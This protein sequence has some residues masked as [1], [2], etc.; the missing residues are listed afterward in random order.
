MEDAFGRPGQRRRNLIVAQPNCIEVPPIWNKMAEAM[1]LKDSSRALGK[2]SEH[3]SFTFGRFKST[4]GVPEISR[5]IV[6]ERGYVIAMQLKAIPF[7][8]QFFR[9]KKVSSGFY[10]V[11]GVSA[12]DLRE[13]PS[14]LLPNPFDV[15]VFY[16]A[17][18]ALDEIAD[19]H[20]TSRVTRLVW[21]HGAYDPVVHGLGRTLL[22]SLALPSRSSKLFVD[23][24][25]Q[26]LNCHFVSIYGGVTLS[27]KRYRGGLSSWQSRRATELLEA[28]LSGNI[29]LGQ[30]AEA[31]GLSVGHFARAFKQTFRRPPYLWLTELRVDRA[32]DLMVNSDL[33]LSEIATQCGFADQSAFN[34]SFKRIHGIP[35]GIWRR[36]YARDN[37]I[38]L[39]MCPSSA[40]RL[41]NQNSRA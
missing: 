27:P 35:P 41:M 34:R 6:G 37:N 36:R 38:R 5:P 29:A 30:V 11:G 28:N 32:R 4:K 19:A 1:R 20:Q 3:A 23:H 7:I 25:L 16:V 9:N 2:L 40:P 14:V 8:E 24:V 39:P 26:A 15:L 13:E 10:P 33:P 21:P 17:Q 12:I 31:C 18:A 22:S